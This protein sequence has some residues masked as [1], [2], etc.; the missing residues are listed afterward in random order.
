MSTSTPD[1]DSTTTQL[2]EFSGKWVIAGMFAFGIVATLTLWIYWYMHSGPFAPLQKAIAA[3]FP[4][5]IPRVDGGQRRMHLGG[6]RLA[7]II[8]RVQFKP[9]EDEARSQAVMERVLALARQ[10]LTMSDW[11]QINI[12]LFYG[13][14][15]RVI[16]SK[17]FEHSLLEERKTAPL[18]SGSP[19]LK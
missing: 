6:P 10:H 5:S 13:E 8:L 14:P 16:H 12:R 7:W 4:K 3:E 11:D 19:E 17:D 9:E 1:P 15:E 2:R 18:P